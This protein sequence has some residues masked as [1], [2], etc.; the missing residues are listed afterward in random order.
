MYC[1]VQVIFTVVV[2]IELTCCSAHMH[3]TSVCVP[4]S[5]HECVHVPACRLFADYFDESAPKCAASLFEGF[6]F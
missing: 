3:T 6:F 2:F 1:I 5:G 4:Q